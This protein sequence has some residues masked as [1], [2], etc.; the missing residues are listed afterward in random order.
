MS[1][2]STC[3]AL[4]LGING[5][6]NRVRSDLKTTHPPLRILGLHCQA[7]KNKNAT[8]QYKRTRIW[9]IKKR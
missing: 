3:T 1:T 9:E 4:G 2:F 5:L 6:A 7:M 8:I